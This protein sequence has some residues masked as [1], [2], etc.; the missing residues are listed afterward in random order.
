MVLVGRHLRTLNDAE[1]GERNRR[2]FI[3]HVNNSYR[4]GL[5]DRNRPEMDLYQTL[6][7]PVMANQTS[8]TPHRGVLVGH[9]L[10]FCQASNIVQ[11]VQR[12]CGFSVVPLSQF[13]ADSSVSARQMSAQANV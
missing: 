6:I 2:G 12:S 1:V 11:P 5:V 3:N 7:N 8:T 10:S 4:L 13:V 9:S